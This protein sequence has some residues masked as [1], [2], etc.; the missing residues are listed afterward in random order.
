[1]RPAPAIYRLSPSLRGLRRP[2][3]ELG[4]SPLAFSAVTE[5]AVPSPEPTSVRAEAGQG[6]RR[7]G[8]C[9]VNKGHTLGTGE[10]SRG[11]KGG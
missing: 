1:M 5:V 9:R 3:L 10:P 8:S 7:Q 6:L 4:S 11:E 2:W